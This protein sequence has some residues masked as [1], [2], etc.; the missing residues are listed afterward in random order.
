[1]CVSQT[2]SHFRRSIVIKNAIM[3]S[4]QLPI[5]AMWK[6]EEY[7]IANAAFHSVFE[8]IPESPAGK[9]RYVLSNLRLWTEDFSRELRIDELPMFRICSS[10]KPIHGLKY[11]RKTAADGPGL[12]FEATGEPFWDDSG[13]ELLGSLVFFKEVTGYTQQIASQAQQCEE[14]FEAIANLIPQLVWTTTPDGRVN[15][16]SLRWREY[17]GMADDQA[18]GHDWDV[19]FHPEDMPKTMEI[20][21]SSLETGTEYCTEYRCRRYDGVWRWMLGRASPLRDGEG[22]IV[23]W[24]GTCTDIDDLIKAKRE[25]SDMRDQLEKVIEC[26]QV[27]LWI[28]NSERCITVHQGYMPESLNGGATPIGEDVYRMCESRIRGPDIERLGK[29]IDKVFSKTTLETTLDLFD[30]V[31]QRWF[32]IKIMPVLSCHVDDSR[33]ERP[34]DRVILVSMDVTGIRK[35]DQELRAKEEDRRD[36]LARANSAK[37]ASEMKSR[38]LAMASHE[39]RTPLAGIIGIA[40]QL[41]DMKL[42]TRQCEFLGMIRSAAENLLIVVNDILDLSRVE[43]GKLQVEKIDF[44]LGNVVADVNSMIRQSSKR[45][46]VIYEYAAQSATL[47]SLNLIGDPARLRQILINLLSNSVKFT[48]KGKVGLNVSKSGETEDLLTLNFVCW[49]TGIGIEKEAQRKLFQPFSQARES[50]SREF[51]GTGLGLAIV[52]NLT[53][54]MGGHVRLESQ[55]GEGCIVT[56]S[57]P[58]IRAAENQ[59]SDVKQPLKAQKSTNTKGDHPDEPS[60]AISDVGNLLGQNTTLS[61]AQRAEIDILV[62]DDNDVNRHIALRTVSKQGFSVSCVEDGREALDYLLKCARLDT[63]PPDIILMDIQMPRL[64]GYEATRIIRNGSLF[65]HTLWAQEIPIIAMTASGLPGEEQKC[66]D[67]GMDDFILKPLRAKLLEEMLLKWIA[68]G[69]RFA[70]E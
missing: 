25:A 2:F 45:K 18:L 35:R 65:D 40:E 20:W 16:Y 64:N 30:Q 10:G 9:Q 47:Q 12:I 11:G 6:D 44:C 70:D 49:D 39:F 4:T 1:M 24:F 5:Y 36:S 60:V 67:A 14:Q 63:K 57:L 46:G 56:V 69:G 55:A 59:I 31:S 29:N 52:K 41:L 23:K 15:W 27:G 3:D 48:T 22:N 26:S 17:T 58:F 66:R 51:G 37:E 38:F 62:V 34:V 7:G 28:I 33:D 21:R 50:T 8:E 43:A 13:T 32:T 68:A 54:L 61:N 53:E 42:N 19:V